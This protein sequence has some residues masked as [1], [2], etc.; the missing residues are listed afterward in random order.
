MKLEI[1]ENILEKYLKQTGYFNNIK[2]YANKQ[3]EKK[4]R[5]KNSLY[6]QIFI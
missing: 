1:K 3:T 6:F 4:Q 2:I 5:K